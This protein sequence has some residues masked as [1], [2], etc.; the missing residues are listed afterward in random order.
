MFYLRYRDCESSINHITIP[1]ASFTLSSTGH[2]SHETNFERQAL[3]AELIKSYKWH[4]KVIL[5][6]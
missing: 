1:G 6:H 4:E 3:Y 2:L 5:L